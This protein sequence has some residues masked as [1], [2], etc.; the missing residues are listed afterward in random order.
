MLCYYGL[1]NKQNIFDIQ[2]F[3]FVSFTGFIMALE[4]KITDHIEAL[5]TDA[6]KVES[7]R[8]TCSPYDLNSSDHPGNLITQVKLR[9]DDNYDE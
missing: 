4:P 7:T 2:P 1:K 5:K 9:G 6:S 3:T 8:K